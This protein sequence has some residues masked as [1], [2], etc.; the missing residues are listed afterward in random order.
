MI[1]TA[2]RIH[3]YDNLKAVIWW[4][5][6]DSSQ[7]AIEAIERNVTARE[8]K[9]LIVLKLEW[10]CSLSRNIQISK[11]HRRNLCIQGKEAEGK[12]AKIID[13]SLKLCGIKACRIQ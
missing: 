5:C 12:S 8:N 9:I 10:L 4:L 3:L 1:G 6:Y 2:K 11:S 7:V 13:L